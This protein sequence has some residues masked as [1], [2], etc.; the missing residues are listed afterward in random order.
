MLEYGV[1]LRLDI[2]VVGHRAARPLVEFRDVDHGDLTLRYV[3]TGDQ[4]AVIAAVQVAVHLHL[5]GRGRWRLHHRGGRAALDQPAAGHPHDPVAVG[6]PEGRDHPET[7]PAVQWAIANQELLRSPGAGQSDVGPVLLLRQCGVERHCRLSYLCQDGQMVLTLL[8]GPMPL[9][10]GEQAESNDHD[11]GG[12]GE[13]DPPAGSQQG[14]HIITIA[15]VGNALIAPPEPDAG[16]S[17]AWARWHARL[18]YGPEAVS[19]LDRVQ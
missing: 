9:P 12:N 7:R 3:L 2:P 10:H 6:L 16:R 14:P 5:A 18:K 13:T 11:Q 17:Q 19:A 4:C 15:A 8:R 1:G